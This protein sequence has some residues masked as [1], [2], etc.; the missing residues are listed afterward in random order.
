[1]ISW[2]EVVPERSVSESDGQLLV[3]LVFVF[4][5]FVVEVFVEGVF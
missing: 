3:T 1:M 2:C 4:V 5:Y